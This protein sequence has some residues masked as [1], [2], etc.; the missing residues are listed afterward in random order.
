VPAVLRVR[1]RVLEVPLEAELTR[2]GDQ[3]AIEVSE[4]SRTWRVKIDRADRTVH[5][6]R[7]SE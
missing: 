6:V 3:V 5:A 1:D 4:A 2:S 7:L